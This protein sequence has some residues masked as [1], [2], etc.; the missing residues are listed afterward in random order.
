MRNPLYELLA[1]KVLSWGV[2]RH[3]RT[4]HLSVSKRTIFPW[5]L[6]MVKVDGRC[7][8]ST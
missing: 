2:L 7:H 8:A 1:F 5:K 3:K 6:G 4:H